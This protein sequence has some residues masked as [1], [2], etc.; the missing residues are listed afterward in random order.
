MSASA[1][2]CL[3]SARTVKCGSCGQRVGVG[4]GR[5]SLMLLLAPGPL[6]AFHLLRIVLGPATP[7][8]MYPVTMIAMAAGCVAMLLLY[9]KFVPLVKR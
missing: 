7:Q 2:L 9:V 6:L 3:G 4:W 8:W 5:S 1:K